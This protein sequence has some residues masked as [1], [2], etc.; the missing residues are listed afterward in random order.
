MEWRALSA[1]PMTAMSS[2]ISSMPSKQPSCKGWSQ[3]FPVLQR[4]ERSSFQSILEWE[5]GLVRLSLTV[6]NINNLLYYSQTPDSCSIGHAMKTW[7][8]KW[9]PKRIQSEQMLRRQTA[10]MYWCRRTTRKTGLKTLSGSVSD[11]WSSEGIPNTQVLRKQ[12]IFLLPHQYHP[13]SI[14]NYD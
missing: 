11:Q 3:S 4:E 9:S 6:K 12:S 8:I 14:N 7:A 13:C 2:Q 1:F 5:E 10:G